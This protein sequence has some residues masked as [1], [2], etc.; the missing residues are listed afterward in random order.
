MERCWIRNSCSNF[1]E[2]ADIIEK[3]FISTNNIHDE[4]KKCIKLESNIT[5]ID[6]KKFDIHPSIALEAFLYCCH[7]K[8]EQEVRDNKYNPSSY[9]THA[10]HNYKL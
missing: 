5:C 6:N 7:R 4:I 10:I 3:L 8:R 2:V 9:I 1:R